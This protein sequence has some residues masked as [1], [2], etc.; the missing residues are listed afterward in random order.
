MRRPL[1]V[2]AVLTMIGVA[3]VF[4]QSAP[5]PSTSE[6][7]ELLNQAAQNLMA[8]AQSMES[9]NNAHYR[10]AIY[11][12]DYQVNTLQAL[13]SNLSTAESSAANLALLEV[14]SNNYLTSSNDN[15]DTDTDFQ[16]GLKS[17][18]TTM[19]NPGSGTNNVGDTPQEILPASDH[20]HQRRVRSPSVMA[21]MMRSILR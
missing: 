5:S 13:T 12:F 19:P 9:G 8:T 6:G 15:N 3:A 18:N 20:E 7:L 14:Y 21:S 2:I 16:T 17:I 10:A 1:F 4:A 11:T